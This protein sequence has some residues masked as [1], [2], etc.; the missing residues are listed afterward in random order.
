MNL[1]VGMVL[2]WHLEKVLDTYKAA[3]RILAF[4]LCFLPAT[5][6][7]RHR[8]RLSINTIYFCRLVHILKNY[9][10]DLVNFH[11]IQF[12]ILSKILERRCG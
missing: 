11:N 6:L 7:Y 3:V 8:K 5:P 1:N 4:R 2:A 9:H 10:F 12:N